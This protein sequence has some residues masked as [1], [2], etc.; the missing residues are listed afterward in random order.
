MDRLTCVAVCGVRLLWHLIWLCYNLVT[1]FTMCLKPPRLMIRGNEK[2]QVW[3]Q[4]GRLRESSERFS[5][6]TGA[7]ATV[8]DKPH[9]S[10]TCIKVPPPPLHLCVQDW[11]VRTGSASAP[12]HPPYA[13]CHVLSHRSVRGWHCAEASQYTR[14]ISAIHQASLHSRGVCY[15]LHP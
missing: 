15:M 3:G 5:G 4:R 2:T 10:H 7:A 11:L 6:R 14:C 12:P 8:Q 13:S 1:V 9:I